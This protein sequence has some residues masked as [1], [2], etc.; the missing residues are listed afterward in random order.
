MMDAIDGREI[1]GIP[2][3][4]AFRARYGNPY[5][6]IH[7]ADIDKSILEGDEARP[8]IAV[9]TVTR[10][11][12]SPGRA[13]G[14]RVDTNGGENAARRWRRGRHEVVDHRGH[15]RRRPTHLRSRRQSRQ[16]AERDMPR[17]SL[18]T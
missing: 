5:A 12:R 18:E 7:R 8:E 6:V 17:T 15:R 4:E 14:R 1:A 13:R 3:A 9:R 2:V 16:R 10:I 11:V